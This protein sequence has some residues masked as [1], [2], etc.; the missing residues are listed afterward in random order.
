MNK[1]FPQWLTAN[2]MIP[3]IVRGNIKVIVTPEYSNNS[4][5]LSLL[6][7]T[8]NRALIPPEE[9]RKFGIR[10]GIAIGHILY[11]IGFD[12]KPYLYQI[13]SERTTCRIEGDIKSKMSRYEQYTGDS[14]ENLLIELLGADPE[15]VLQSP[16]KNI[17][18]IEHK[19]TKAGM[20]HNYDGTYNGVIKELTEGKSR[21]A[22]MPYTKEHTHRGKKWFS[23]VESL[24]QLY[25]W[26]TERDLEELMGMGYVL[27]RF[28][29]LEYIIKGSEVLFT[30]ESVVRQAGINLQGEIW[31]ESN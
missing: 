1:L 22:L 10:L 5:N 19:E 14:I 12:E 4:I 18:R 23:G 7:L 30:R 2:I 16:T 13:L 6:D 9:V 28:S 29:A 25:Q 15:R 17:Y 26:F 11:T 21:E 8:Y 24:E 27:Y 31:L 3:E 20:W